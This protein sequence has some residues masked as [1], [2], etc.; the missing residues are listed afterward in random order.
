VA[1][2]RISRQQL[3]TFLKDPQS[4]REFERMIG[5]LVTAIAD[6]ETAIAG[7]VGAQDT[8]DQAAHWADV[9]RIVA[10]RANALAE[11][12]NSLATDAEPRI[13]ALEQEDR[14]PVEL[15]YMGW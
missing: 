14:Y 5:S 7:A 3:S 2:I 12:A 8:A 9:A 1:E 4:I 15:A 11:K 13:D 10:E 6:V